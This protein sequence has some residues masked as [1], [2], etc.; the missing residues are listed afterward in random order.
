MRGLFDFFTMA[1]LD[2]FHFRNNHQEIV[3]KKKDAKSK[4]K[5]VPKTVYLPADSSWT[6]KYYLN[7][8]DLYY[9]DRELF[10]K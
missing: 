3:T 5:I 7:K 10:A 6:D 2:H 9:K 4:E 8:S 1:L